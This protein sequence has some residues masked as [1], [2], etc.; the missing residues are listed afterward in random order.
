MAG[1]QGVGGEGAQLF[2]E[3]RRFLGA[4]QCKVLVVRR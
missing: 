4:P 1:V 2:G 3:E